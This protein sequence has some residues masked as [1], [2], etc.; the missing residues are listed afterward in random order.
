MP[1]RAFFAPDAISF[2][3][4][5][6]DHND[7][8]W[9][10]QNKH[11]YQKSIVEP[12]LAFIGTLGPKLSN[13]V[14]GVTYDLGTSGSGSLQRI[15]RDVRFSKDKSPYKDYVGLRFW[16]ERPDGKKGPGPG[17]YVHIGKDGAR[18]YAG[19]HEFDRQ[20]LEAFRTAVAE[21]RTGRELERIASRLEKAG[22][23]VGGE[24]FKRVP[25][26]YASDHPRARFL[27]FNTLYAASPVI[28]PTGSGF[29]AACEKACLATSELNAWT[30]KVMGEPQG[31]TSRKG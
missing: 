17:Y 19:Q 3:R 4:D 7:R 31:S 14:P 22:Y 27:K 29:A 15:H 16:Y 9:F 21:D 11:R 10:A 2:L 18:V 6:A 26:G 5:L 1:D 13:E 30:R 8:T 24:H 20:S 28:D 25:S 12:A 23:E